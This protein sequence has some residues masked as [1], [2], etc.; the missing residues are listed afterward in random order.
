M[1]WLVWTRT[2]EGLLGLGV[3]V[4]G[5]CLKPGPQQVVKTVQLEVLGCGPTSIPSQT[6]D[7]PLNLSFS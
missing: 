2:H 6:I 7:N 4:P 3:A 1:M 5:Q